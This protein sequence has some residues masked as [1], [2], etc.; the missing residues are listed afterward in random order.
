MSLARKVICSMVL[1][2]IIVTPAIAGEFVEDSPLPTKPAL[3]G[4]R[5]YQNDRFGFS[6]AYPKKVLNPSKTPSA[7]DAGVFTSSDGK[8]ELCAFGQRNTLDQTLAENLE[9]ELAHEKENSKDF[10]VTVQQMGSNWYAV[11]GTADNTVFYTKTFFT[12]DN[13]INSFSFSYPVEQKAKYDPIVA[14]IEKS[15]VPHQ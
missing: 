7:K 9:H 8:A 15:F 3:P 12:G 5:V 6:I 2:S 11:S 13:R 10:K 1:A 14:E 4:Y